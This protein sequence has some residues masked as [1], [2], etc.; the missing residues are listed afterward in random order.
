MKENDF[1][2][3][4]A[5][6]LVEKYGT[7]VYIYFESILRERCRDI[8][9]LLPTK[10]FRVNYS[11]KAN[12]NLELLKIIRSEGIDV[13]AM[14]PG[15]ILLQMKAGYDSDHILYIGNNV[16]LT[17]LQFAVDKQITVS[18]DSISQLELLG[19]IGKGTKVS[20]RINPGLGVGHNE[21]VVTAGE[22]TKFGIQISFLDQAL[23]LV[24]KH[25][26]KLVGI[27]Q[28]IGSLFLEPDTYLQ[29]VSRL[30]DVA[31]KI[32]MPLEFIDFGGGF[33]VPYEEGQQ[34]LD[35]HKMGQRLNELL[36]QFLL[37]YINKDVI[38]KVEPGRFIPA[39][40]GYLLGEVHAVK[41]NFERRYVGTD[42]GF[43]V[44]MRPVLY[45]SYHEVEVI[46]D[47][48]SNEK[49]IATIVGNICETGDIIAAERSISKCSEGDIVCV[50]NAGAYGF[51]MSSNYNCRL[52]PA[53]VLIDSEGKDYL[54]RRRDTYEDLMRNFVE[55]PVKEVE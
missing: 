53:E 9:N 29:C 36:D 30:L 23:E 2:R 3:V 55:L 28:H 16:S 5:K 18:V 54:I 4:H 52:R 41:S 10:N 40:C 15:E 26:L 47:Q 6:E 48:T 38:F 25:G 43:N 49:E 45:D 34:Q 27:N 44:L 24:N 39:E 14:S 31:M 22:K 11:A 46:T 35:L 42:L 21:K 7:P 20:L 12:S 37:Q 50:H 32:D 17:E 1:I 33:G 19:S 8:K 13:D 51:A